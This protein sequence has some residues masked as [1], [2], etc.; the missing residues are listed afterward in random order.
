LPVRRRAG[1]KVPLVPWC[2]VVLPRTSE[3]KACLIAGAH[4]SPPIA[5]MIETINTN[6]V[7]AISIQKTR[8]SAG[9]G[10]T[11]FWWKLSQGQSLDRRDWTLTMLW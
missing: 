6:D 9:S 4:T 2:D 8:L 5:K 7:L 10:K 1:I 11:V 3:W